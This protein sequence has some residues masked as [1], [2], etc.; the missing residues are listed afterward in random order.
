MGWTLG[1]WAGY[2]TL[3]MQDPQ[4]TLTANWSRV[5]EWTLVLNAEALHYAHAKLH[6]TDSLLIGE[7]R[8]PLSNVARDDHRDGMSG[9]RYKTM[10][11]HP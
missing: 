8:E 5:L 11:R 1:Q 3:A 6:R 9:S 2:T 7:R 4:P 10:W